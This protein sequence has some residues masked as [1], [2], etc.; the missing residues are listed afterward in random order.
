MTG[1][2]DPSRSRPSTPH[3]R[4]ARSRPLNGETD[5]LSDHWV[6]GSRSPHVRPEPAGCLRTPGDLAV[7]FDPRTNRTPALD[8][9]DEA[10]VWAAS[11]PDARLIIAMPPQEGGRVLYTIE[12]I[13]ATSPSGPRGGFRCGCCTPTP[14]P[15]SRSCRLSPSWP[16][17]GV[18]PSATTSTCTAR[19]CPCPCGG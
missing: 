10:L 6:C 5:H 12:T 1:S 18:A 19:P 8:L 2:A 4:P 3:Y 9:I 7:K 13:V 17:V 11:T 14:T 16:G 15:G